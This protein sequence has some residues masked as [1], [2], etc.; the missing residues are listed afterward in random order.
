MHISGLA[1]TLYITVQHSSSSWSNSRQ[2]SASQVLDVL[3]PGQRLR[4]VLN[5]CLYDSC[6]GTIEIIIM[7]DRFDEAPRVDKD[8]VVLQKT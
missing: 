2:K 7:T 1:F 5:H 6:R 4:A 8:V 3:G